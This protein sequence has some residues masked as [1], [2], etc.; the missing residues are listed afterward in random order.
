MNP[1][2]RSKIIRKWDKNGG[3]LIM[4]YKLF[5]KL[6]VKNRKK[7]SPLSSSDLIIC[8]EGH[9]LK[10]PTTKLY[11]FINGLSTKRL[12]G[13]P[14]QNNQ[15]EYFHMVNLVSPG[16]AGNAKMFKGIFEEP[17]IAGRNPN[18]SDIT[19]FLMRKRVYVLNRLLENC[20][21]TADHTVCNEFLKPKREFNVYLQLTG[22]QVTLYKVFININSIR[23]NDS[24]SLKYNIKSGTF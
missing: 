21:K 14:V 10:N 1:L 23:F 24:M 20:V 8:D 5:L 4:G 15:M 3:V 7:S 12:T 19:K 16:V 13:T 17:I 6:I 22:F 9:Q 11:K 2:G 18:T